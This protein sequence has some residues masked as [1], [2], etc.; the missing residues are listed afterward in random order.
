MSDLLQAG[1]LKEREI[2]E[3]CERCLHRLC[4]LSQQFCFYTIIR[5]APKTPQKPNTHTHTHTWSLCR[6]PTICFTQHAFLLS[7]F[8]AWISLREF[9]AFSCVLLPPEESKKSPAHLSKN[10]AAGKEMKT[11]S[12][13][14]SDCTYCV[15]PALEAQ[16]SQHRLSFPTADIASQ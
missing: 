9:A 4:F 11:T 15:H 10:S 13:H 12:Q 5:P 2:I 8:L 1:V 14:Y 7:V 6:A 16:G 3:A